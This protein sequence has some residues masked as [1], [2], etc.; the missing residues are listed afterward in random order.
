MEAICDCALDLMEASKKVLRD[1]VTKKPVQV[2][3]AIE[4]GP[5][6]ACVSGTSIP[7]FDLVGKPV[8]HAGV[9]ILQAGADSIIVGP[10]TRSC[11][12]AMYKVTE[13]SVLTID[14]LLIL[15]GQRLQGHPECWY[16]PPAD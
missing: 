14:I 9:I 2:C 4:T 8:D 10:T 6:V 5:C 3:I 7:K 15:S 13:E 11:L 16:G 1:P 12:P